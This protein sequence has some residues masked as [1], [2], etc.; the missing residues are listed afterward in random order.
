LC[1]ADAHDEESVQES[2]AIRLFAVFR[3]RTVVFVYRRQAVEGHV[4]VFEMQV[5]AGRLALH[6]V[7]EFCH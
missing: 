7:H 2:V 6:R 1:D 4:D 3:T 5:S